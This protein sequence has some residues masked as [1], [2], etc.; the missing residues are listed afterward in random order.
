MQLLLSLPM[1]PETPPDWQLSPYFVV[2]Q[3]QAMMT[4]VT[5]M[6]TRPATRIVGV[7]NRIPPST[8]AGGNALVGGGVPHGVR[9]APH[10]V[11]GGPHGVGRGPHGVAQWALLR[12]AWALLRTTWALLRT[13]WASLRT[14]W[15]LLRTACG[16]SR[17]AWEMRWPPTEANGSPSPSV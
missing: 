1:S 12:T 7:L 14:A 4:A 6:D 16:R 11:G 5:T 8:V 10:G 17:T 15:A 2:S 9:T 13:A 3:P